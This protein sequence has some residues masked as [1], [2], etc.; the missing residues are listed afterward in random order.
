MMSSTMEPQINLKE[1]LFKMYKRLKTNILKIAMLP[2]HRK[3][4]EKS[5][6]FD[7]FSRYFRSN[8]NFNGSVLFVLL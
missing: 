8:E 2:F 6:D 1:H 5:G 4:Q 7:I 3:I